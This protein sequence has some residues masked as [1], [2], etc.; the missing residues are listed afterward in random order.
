MKA[1]IFAAGVGSRLKPFTDMHPKALAKVGGMTMLER[2]IRRVHEAGAD[3]IVVNVHH[4]A[5]QIIEYLHLHN[6][7]GL[8]IAV[9]DESDV[10]LDTGGGLLHA[11]GLLNAE[12]DEPVI[13]HNADILTDAPLAEMVDSHLRSEADATLLVGRRRSSRMLYFDSCNRLA[14]WSNLKTGEGKPVGFNPASPCCRPLAF[15]GVHIVRPS[16]VFPYLEKYAAA[17]GEVFSITPFYVAA[18]SDLR[19]VGFTPHN[20][21]MW[22]DIGTPEKLA[23]AEADLA[24]NGQRHS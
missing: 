12:S 7:F 13:L 15:G 5:T 1:L 17:H 24:T 21:Y 9:S 2:T 6:D 23:C 3:R 16:A 22:H 14:G 10:L 19:I 18:L 8:D 20:Y 11:R 4:F